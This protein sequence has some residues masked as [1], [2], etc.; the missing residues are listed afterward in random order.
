MTKALVLL[1]GGLDSMLAAR[2]L[3]EQGVKV[4]GLS[5]KSYFFN[6]AKAKVAAEQLGIELIE[7]DFSAEHLAMVKSP[8]HGYGKNMNPCIDCHALMLK[9][10]AEHLTPN[11]L[12]ARR[13][14]KPPLRPLLSGGQYD[15]VATGEVL[16]Q[17]PMSQ[18]QQAIEMVEEISG[19]KGRLIRPLSAKLLAE[20]EAEKAGLVQ[21]HK[22]LDISGRSRKP[23]LALVKKYGIKEYSSPGGGCLL[24]DRTFS[25]KL[26]KMIEY[27]SECSGNDIE[28]LKYGRILWL[29][30]TSHQPPSQPPPLRSSRERGAKESVLLVIGRNEQDNE[31]LES[32]AVKDDV[33]IQ[34]K[35]EAGP[36]SLLRIKNYE[37]KITNE[38]PEINVPEG[39]KMGEL[40]LG[41]SKSE[42]EIIKVA[43][44]LTG[45][46]AA[47][48]RGKTVKMEVRK[49]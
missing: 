41:E 4:T 46:Y 29:A 45:Y 37:S 17:R 6:T 36:T 44:L 15:F 9:R 2:V 38:M 31:K 42:K 7:A 25:E 33:L 26:I 3:M 23:Q 16:G 48:A 18:N 47:K 8:K 13:G 5:F 32:L 27:W 10:A 21:R 34:L 35:E 14:G 24:T 40:K 43:A 39:L 22:L 30:M 28:L 19:I 12:L 20:S 11:P 1:S 49:I